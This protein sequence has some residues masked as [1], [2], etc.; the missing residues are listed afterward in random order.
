MTGNGNEHDDLQ[1]NIER[2]GPGPE[3]IDEVSQA[4]F[5]HPSVRE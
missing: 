1:I 3:D 2:F 5:H 4:T